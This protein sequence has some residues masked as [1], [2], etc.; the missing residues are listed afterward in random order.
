MPEQD[1]CVFKNGKV[2]FPSGEKIDPNACTVADF[3][4][5]VG[6]QVAA[7]TGPLQN[8]LVY[9]YSLG[10][11][12]LFLN[13]EEEGDNSPVQLFWIEL[14]RDLPLVQI[15]KQYQVEP[16][17]MVE[18]VTV[19]DGEVETIFTAMFNPTFGVQFDWKSKMVTTFIFARL[20]H[21]LA[22]SC[23]SCAFVRQKFGLAHP[24]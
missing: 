12:R 5:L 9:S 6:D 21:I 2:Y 16:I 13:S 4:P 18:E 19:E 22:C 14:K 20:E 8:Q 17:I 24:A 10:S 3:Q 1:L 23:D 11:L 7:V 15:L